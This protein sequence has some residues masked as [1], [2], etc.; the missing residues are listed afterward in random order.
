MLE[1]GKKAET[2][3]GEQRA[4]AKTKTNS[5]VCVC[6]VRSQS[7][8][9]S[10]ASQNAHTSFHPLARLL[11]SNE[12]LCCGKTGLTEPVSFFGVPLR[13]CPEELFAALRSSLE[14]ALPFG[15]AFCSSTCGLKQASRS[16]VVFTGL[17][18]EFTRQA[19]AEQSKK[20]AAKQSMAK[21]RQ[22][23]EN[24]QQSLDPSLSRL[25]S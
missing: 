10:L 6:C 1:H 5:C 16:C 19:N 22:G 11:G 21:A 4:R 15:W 13:E 8:L 2:G 14:Q 9:T 25:R 20:K 18:S 12:L 23:K 3:G 17:N 7:P 24:T